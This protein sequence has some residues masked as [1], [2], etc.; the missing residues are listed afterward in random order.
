LLDLRFGWNGMTTE[1]IKPLD[2]SKI[3]VII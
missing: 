3:I 2:I 1:K